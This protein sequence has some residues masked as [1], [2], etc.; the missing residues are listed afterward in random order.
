MKIKNLIKLI[1]TKINKKVI[2]E[3]TLVSAMAS[4][5]YSDKMLKQATEDKLDSKEY[6]QQRKKSAEH[7]VNTLK[8]KGEE[9][10]EDTHTKADELLTNLEDKTKK[11]LKDYL[12]N[13]KFI[14]TA[15]QFVKELSNHI[16]FKAVIVHSK[17][18]IHTLV[19]PVLN[20]AKNLSK[21]PQKTIKELK[22]TSANYFKNCFRAI[23]NTKT[24]AVNATNTIALVKKKHS[25]KFTPDEKKK[26][27]SDR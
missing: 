16:T 21:E 10:T 2:L 20:T 6:W 19:S 9:E 17:H 24:M 12:K 4:L 3:D 15:N 26:L 25:T 23:K 13:P 11:S 8:G 1:E 5:K 18:Q 7:R 27:L 22:Q 14:K